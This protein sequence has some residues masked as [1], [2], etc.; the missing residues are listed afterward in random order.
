MIFL[1]YQQLEFSQS[2]DYNKILENIL[3]IRLDSVA[4]FALYNQKELKP[5]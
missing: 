3:Q 4:D 1:I 5:L 2:K